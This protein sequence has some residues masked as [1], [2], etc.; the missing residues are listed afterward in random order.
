MAEEK[1]AD[2]PANRA[3]AVEPHTGG[4]PRHLYFGDEVAQAK[5]DKGCQGVA[6]HRR[7]CNYVTQCGRTAR[8]Y[9]PCDRWRHRHVHAFSSTQNLGHPLSRGGYW[10]LA[11]G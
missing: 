2:E 7:G 10:C 4:M 9:H 1:H 5:P 11:T 6:S 8:L 3:L